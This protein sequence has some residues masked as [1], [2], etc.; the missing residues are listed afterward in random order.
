MEL[1]FKNI[2]KLVQNR[3]QNTKIPKDKIRIVQNDVN[4]ANVTLQHILQNEQKIQRNLIFLQ[5][6]VMLI[7]ENINKL[8]IKETLVEQALLFEISL[9]QY[10]YET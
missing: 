2:K 6:Q 8:Q 3:Q 9:N 5:I 1:I 7:T 10:A 4:K